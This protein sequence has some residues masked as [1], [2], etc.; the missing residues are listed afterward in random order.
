M[1]RAR[2][3]FGFPRNTFCP[4]PNVSMPHI[5]AQPPERVVSIAL[6]AKRRIRIANKLGISTASEQDLD[7]SV[8]G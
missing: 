8:S 2:A 6:D 3:S 5:G 7:I 4:G 1:P